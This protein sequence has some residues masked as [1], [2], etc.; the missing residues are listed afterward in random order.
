M[1]GAVVWVQCWER[2]SEKKSTLI[3][4]EKW[5]P[6]G[7][8]L[9]LLPNMR[10]TP[11]AHSTTIL[12]TFT[13][14][15]AYCDKHAI[16]VISVIPRFYNR[17]RLI[18]II[19]WLT[20]WVLSERCP[21]WFGVPCGSASTAKHLECE[22]EDPPRKFPFCVAALGLFS[23]VASSLSGPEIHPQAKV[24]TVCIKSTTVERG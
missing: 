9:Q 3:R 10:G 8:G 5:P 2:S 11:T 17:F 22:W 20:V 4:T 14:L 19:L 16:D 21:L 24:S 12:L 13:A 23:S 15:V 18:V 7:S 6:R 1:F